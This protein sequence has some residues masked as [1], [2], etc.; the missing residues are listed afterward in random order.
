MIILDAEERGDILQDGQ[1]KLQGMEEALQQA[2]EELGAAR[3]LDAGGSQAGP[4]CGDC[5]L[6]HAAG[7]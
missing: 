2:K 1:Q 6:A 4:G 5:R 3:P 7:G